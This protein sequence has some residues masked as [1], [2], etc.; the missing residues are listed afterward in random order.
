MNELITRSFT[1]DDLSAEDDGSVI[2]G[3]AA[4]FNQPTNIGNYFE[5]VIDTRAF[6]ECELNDVMFL[7]NHNMNSLPLARSTGS[8]DSTMKLS[9]DSKGLC[10]EAR[11]DTENNS[12]ARAFYSAVKRKDIQ[13]MSFAFTIREQTWDRLDTKL[14]LRK[15]TGIRKVIEVSGVNRP[16]YDGTDISARS[17]EGALKEI[18]EARSKIDNSSLELEKLKIKIL[19]L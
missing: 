11:L 1:F 15:I 18:E 17:A 19:N 2:R 3:H 10:I 7:V 14:P 9:I 6:D 13:G 8:A 16:A 4:V 5:E 12:D